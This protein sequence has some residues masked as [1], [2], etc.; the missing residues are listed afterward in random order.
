MMHTHVCTGVVTH[1]Y[2][3]GLEK[4]NGCS[5]APLSAFSFE[6]G[7]PIELQARRVAKKLQ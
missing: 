2:A 1:S 4:D 5:T 7:S 3:Q 6:T